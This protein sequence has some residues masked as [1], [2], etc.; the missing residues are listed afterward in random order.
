MNNDTLDDL[1]DVWADQSE[2]DTLRGLPEP[3]DNNGIIADK[4]WQP[5]RCFKWHGGMIWIKK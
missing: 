5:S 2:L 1:A 3:T 4:G